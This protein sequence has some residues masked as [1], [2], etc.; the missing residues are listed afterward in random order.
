MCYF[1]LQR[2]KKLF[3]LHKYAEK[4]LQR[5]HKNA[6]FPHAKLHK[7]VSFISHFNTSNIVFTFVLSVGEEHYIF[8]PYSVRAERLKVILLSLLRSIHVL[9][10]TEKKENRTVKPYSYCI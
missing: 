10:K 1:R 8:C 7:N 3:K 6:K 4:H 9:L 5:L 2:Y